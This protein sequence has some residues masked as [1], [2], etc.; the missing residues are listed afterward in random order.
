MISKLLLSTVIAASFSS[1]SAFAEDT[2]FFA[3][4]DVT[5]GMAS[6][7]SSTT[8]GG[9]AIA[10]GG[11]VDN[12][13]FGGTI[14]VGG[15]AGYR[16]NPAVSAFISYQHVQGDV[17][18]DA[19]FPLFGVASSFNGAAI[20]NAAMGNMAYDLALSDT[21]SIKTSVGAG[22]SFNALSGIVETDK[23]TGLFLSDVADHT[24]ISPTAQIG[25]G[26]QH[27]ISPN[28]VLGLNASVSYTGSFETGSTRSGN[29]GVTAITPY[30]INDV[31]RAGL[32]ASMR[33]T[34]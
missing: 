2:G 24:H 11:V 13:K 31:W 15:H 23:P 17:G 21:T 30:K 4:L 10:G 5:G 32:G 18:W 22:L 20:S 1:A 7:S 14:G 19:V 26:I 28:V 12:V 9:A 6:G 16:L 3:G 8:K 25:A 34:F 29:L 27:T 33:F